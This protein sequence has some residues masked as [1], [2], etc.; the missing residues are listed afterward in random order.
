MTYLRF[1]SSL[2][3]ARVKLG[4]SAYVFMKWFQRE[5]SLCNQSGLSKRL[6]LRSRQLGELGD[7]RFYCGLG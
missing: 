3:V 5:I 2:H 6:L 7:G 1:L 4:R